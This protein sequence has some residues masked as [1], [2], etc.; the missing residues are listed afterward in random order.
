M[1]G[2]FHL[3]KKWL[4]DYEDKSDNSVL[5]YSQGLR[6]V[7]DFADAEPRSFK[8]D[9]IAQARL[10]DIVN[11][12]RGSRAIQKATLNQTLAAVKSFYEFCEQ[13][14]LSGSGPDVG[15]IRKV[16]GLKSE[17]ENPKYYTGPELE[18][19]FVAASEERKEDELGVGMMWP[20]RDLAMFAFLACLGLR[21][22]ELYTAE[23]EWIR[24]LDKKTEVFAVM[25]KG[26][27][28]RYIPLTPEL[29]SVNQE[30][31]LERVDRFGDPPS[32]TTRAPLPLF[33][34]VTNEVFDYQKLRYWL[35]ALNKAAK[36]PDY[37]LHALRHTAAVQWAASGRA[38]NEI[39]DLLGH[40]SIKTTGIYTK[41]AGGELYD[42]VQSSLAN[43]LTGQ[44]LNDW[45]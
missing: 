44:A 40:A 19:L 28:A 14:G 34:T 32:S 4:R 30:W 11:E 20:T 22:A 33:V 29:I 15:R 35:R 18:R 7:I 36:V 3:W 6:R 8:P 5:A 21:A 10:T 1:G 23:V 24:P 12:M 37:S 41:L 25:G 16:A 26:M 39:Q 17:P 27:K 38:M 2:A 13:D 43:R 31:Q 42:A 9:D 45:K